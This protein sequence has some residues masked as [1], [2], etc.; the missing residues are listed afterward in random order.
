M[1]SDF[2]KFY[3]GQTGRSSIAR[4]DEDIKAINHPYV[5]SKFVEHILST[6]HKYINIQTNTQILHK[7]Q[8]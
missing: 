6:G 1:C 8:I 4:Y 2:S 5:K 7:T 3:I